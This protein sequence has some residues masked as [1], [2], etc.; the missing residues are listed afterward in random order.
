ML[1]I[2]KFPNVFIFIVSIF[3]VFLIGN[4]PYAI[5]ALKAAPSRPV[6]DL[7]R[8][9]NNAAFYDQLSKVASLL[10]QKPNQHAKNMALRWAINGG[11]DGHVKTRVAI[12]RLLLDAGANVNGA[13]DSNAPYPLSMTH[14]AAV[15]AIL[16]KH[17]AFA[18]SMGV[19]MVCSPN[20]KNPVALLKVM[21]KYGFKITATGVESE[22]LTVLHCAVSEN[23]QNLVKFA[24]NQGA[25]VNARDSAGRTPI[26]AAKSKRV[27]DILADNG[28]SLNVVD[29]QGLTPLHAT[30]LNGPRRRIAWLLAAGANPNIRDTQGETP[31]YSAAALNRPRVMR[32]LL[33]HGARVNIPSKTGET[34]LDVAAR[35]D[36]LRL[37]QLLL[38]HGARINQEDQRGWTPLEY[39]AY[40]NHGA[41]VALLLSHHADVN[42]R[43]HEGLTAWQRATSADVRALLIA[44]G[45]VGGASTRKPYEVRACQEVVQLANRGRLMRLYGPAGVSG[46]PLAPSDEWDDRYYLERQRFTLQ[47]SGKPYILGT[48][49]G[50]VPRYL[51]RIGADDVEQIICEFEEVPSGHGPATKIKVLTPFDRLKLYA[52]DHFIRLSQE[53]AKWPGLG[54]ARALVAARR[55]HED[56][57]AFQKDSSTRILNDAIDANRVDLLTYYLHHGIGLRLIRSKSPSPSIRSRY[58]PPEDYSPLYTAVWKGRKTALKILLQEG[59]NPNGRG[60]MQRRTALAEAVD[61]GSVWAT[62]TLLA[63]GANPNV[64]PPYTA[65]TRIAHEDPAS[66]RISRAID[67]LLTHGANPNPWIYD[68]M[69]TVAQGKGLTFISEHMRGPQQGIGMRWVTLALSE[70]G[71]PYFRLGQLLRKAIAIRNFTSCPAGASKKMMDLCLPNLLKSTDHIM[72]T[73]YDARL[74]EH[75][76][77][78][79]KMRIQQRRW[80]RMRDLKCHIREL[81]RINLSGWYAYVLSNRKRA[82][83]VVKETQGISMGIARAC[84]GFQF[85]RHNAQASFAPL[86]FP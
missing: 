27:F 53:A 67:L 26:F 18:S 43:D 4:A 82:L 34:P 58:V 64:S 38:T 36:E 41:M 29:T 12:I 7:S 3:T 10:K 69:G 77:C 75:P 44:H 66:D 11:N 54:G 23:N 13:S 85:V 83:C 33:R 40:G 45:A 78:A 72:T 50:G 6:V 51:S 56:P 9:L 30:V 79:P 55:H 57:D 22:R 2:D 8:A 52:K 65:Q 49:G 17:G 48:Y 39:A 25:S 5:A 19:G 80:L 68:M 1:G 74:K 59:A 16:L 81:P 70:P 47:L 60:G 62:R 73:L 24:L 32:L 15:A 28:A 46:K 76:S 63:Y 14:Q 35:K 31:L 20:T 61:I 21:M 86:V 42:A 37:A 71:K 84:A